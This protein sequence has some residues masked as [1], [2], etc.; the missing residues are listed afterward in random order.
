VLIGKYRIDNIVEAN[1]TWVSRGSQEQFH[2]VSVARS[3]NGQMATGTAIKGVS[4]VQSL[5]RRL[6]GSQ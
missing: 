4:G 5:A 2:V 1:I 3:F 6:C